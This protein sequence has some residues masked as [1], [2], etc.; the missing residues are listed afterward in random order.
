[1]TPMISNNLSPSKNIEYFIRTTC[2]RKANDP[3][4]RI[5]NATSPSSN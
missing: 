5:Q 1:M 3:A 2:H 4:R